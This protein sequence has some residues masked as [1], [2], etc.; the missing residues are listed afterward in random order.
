M[1]KTNKWLE[2]D[3]EKLQESEALYHGLFESREE[4]IQ[5]CELVFN[6]K[7]KPVDNIVLNINSAYE[8][9]SGLKKEE[10]IGKRIKD[11]LSV[12]EQV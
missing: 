3:V 12:V 11:I 9:H 4:A 6:D 8:K 1:D 7:G 5:I 10:V 2:K